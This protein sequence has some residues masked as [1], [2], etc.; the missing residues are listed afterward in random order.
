MLSLSGVLRKLRFFLQPRALE[1][2]LDDEIRFHL[3]MEEATHLRAGKNADE[4][5]VLALRSF[6]VVERYKDESREALGLQFF[7]DLKR[8][9]R[10]AARTFARRPGATTITVLTLALGIGATTAIYGAVYGVLLAPLPYSDSERIITVWQRDD[11]IAG[12]REEMSAPNFLDLKERNHTFASIAAAEPYSLDYESPDGAVRFRNARVTEEFFPIL[13]TAALHGRTFQRGDYVAGRDRVVVLSHRLWSQRFQSDSSIVGRTLVLDSVPQKVVGIMPRGFE[14]PRR[15][16]TW[17]PKIFTEAERQNRA[18]A[19]YTVFGRLRPNASLQSAERDL[20]GIAS[21]LAREYPRT[22]ARVGMSLVPLPTEILGGARKALLVLLGAVVCVLLIACANVANLQLAAAVRRQREFAIRTAIGA[23]RTR[24]IRQLLTE[25][26]LLAALGAAAGIVLAQLGIAA[27]RLVAPP[28]LPRIEQL[29]LA[30]PVLWFGLGLT[31]VT[32]LLFGLAPIV[33]ATRLNLQQNLAAD[34]PASTT[35]VHK[36]R[37]GSALVV[38]EVALALVL[39][40]GAG[41]LGQSFASLLQVERGFRSEGVAA[42]TLQAWSYYPTRAARIGFVK[43]AT[44]RLAGLPGVESAAMTSSL[45]LSDRIGQESS[46]LTVDG[47][48]SEKDVRVAASTPNY[49]AT[50]RIPVRRGRIF[51]PQDDSASLPVAIVNEALARQYWPAGNP[52]GRRITFAFQGPPVTREIV[53][54]VGNVRHDGLHADPPPTVFI[55]HAQAPT[56]AVHLVVSARRGNAEQIVPAIKRELSAMNRAMPVSDVVTL[57][58]L[59]DSSLRERRFNLSLLTAFAL[60]ALVLATVG[61]YG[62]MS[63]LTSERTHEIGIRMALGADAVAVLMMI[64]RQGLQVAAVGV[65]IGL[66][67]AVVVTRLLKDMLFDVTPLDPVTF[68]FGVAV[69]LAVAALACLV[70]ANRAARLDAAQALRQ[71]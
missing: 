16:D 34:S 39:L 65:A 27:I 19:F 53:G 15:E 2:D 46:G 58:S 42:A 41:L 40:V 69:L 17:S 54:V 11:R 67:G 70:P 13:G 8:D 37:L 5:R 21:Q 7:D 23:G 32:A 31:V 35:G 12:S 24:L 44:G 22:N 30:G 29:S 68:L 28:D 14:L 38:A 45:P 61:I 9:I 1:R 43:E 6:G 71:A 66:F 20:K 64:L 33:R 4:A 52:I 3:E 63:G 18:A 57:D 10:F 59:L 36:R 50:L 48:Q 51:G 47:I 55:P 25:S 60:A 49:F 56:G 26:L 62:V